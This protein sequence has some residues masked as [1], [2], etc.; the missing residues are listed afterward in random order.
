MVCLALAVLL[1][2]GLFVA[3]RVAAP[4][5]IPMRTEG[6]ALNESGSPLPSGTPIR[7]FVDGVEY[8][9]AS[10]VQD[11][12]GAFAVLTAG[13]SKTGANVSDT[14]NVQ[15]GANLGD[16]LI[17][18]A[19]GFTAST[20]VFREVDPWVPAGI[21]VHDLNLGSGASTPQPIKVQGLVT[22]PAQAGNQY[23]FVCNPT[24]STVSLADY[25]LERN[26]PG[27]YLGPR[28]DLSGSL[29]AGARDRVNLTSSSWLMASGDSLK[30]VYRNPGG[31]GATAGGRPL[32]VDR[33][34]FNATQNGTLTWEPANTVMGDAD[35]PGPGQILQR[36]LA[37]TDT[38]G[39][40]DFAL[41]TEPGLASNGPP[42][43]SI[44]APAVGEAIAA[45]STYT[46]VWS[47]SD[48]VFATAYIHVWANL[49]IGNQTTALVVDGRGVTSVAW[50]VP[51]AV[52]SDVVLRIDVEDPFG[53]HASATRSFRVTQQSLIVIAIAVLIVV[54]LVAFL[55]FAYWQ[56]RKRKRTP[57]PMSPPPPMAPASVAEVPPA[58]IAG[59]L[60]AANRKV[61]PRCHMSVNA[62]DV[63]CFFCGY[64]FPEGAKPP[65]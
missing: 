41:A 43:V 54:V 36:D 33:V 2:A 62:A 19:G 16:A 21:A 39:P 18:A 26:A 48:D 6:R 47:L 17:Y 24:G 13:N 27:A 11:G 31:A 37:C 65:P 15:E 52:L 63:T 7:T 28:I 29:A 32:V 45:G 60:A 38:N 12:S 57:P 46:F 44:V 25:Y 23:V 9:N 51:N 8:S 14:P 4:P 50:A 34:E 5:P 40:G 59:G 1:V 22:Q 35:A 61:C 64:K 20:R 42:T 49:T 53:A 55:L 10:S 56:A 58:G 30:L 3:V